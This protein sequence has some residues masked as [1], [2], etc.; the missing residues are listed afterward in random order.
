MIEAIVTLCLAASPEICRDHLLPD[1][2]GDR[3][4][5]AQYQPEDPAYLPAMIRCEG[6]PP[7]AS[8]SEVAPGVFVH[9]GQ[10][11]EGTSETGGDLSNAGFI[12]GQQSVAV[13]DSGGSRATG[14]ALFRALRRITDKPVSHLILTHMH[15]D[16]VLGATVFAEAGAEVV[17]HAGL[18]RALADRRRSYLD[19][20]E[21]LLGRAHLIG[22]ALPRID[23]PIYDTTRIDLGGRVLRV[24][25]WPR[26]H[27]GTD[28]T[29]N[30]PQSDTLFAGDLIFDLHTPAL[31]GSLRGWQKVLTDMAQL[32]PAHVVP[33]HGGPVM[34]WAEAVGPMQRYLDVLARDTQAALDQGLSLGQSIGRIATS[35]APH[36]QL[37]ETYNPRN[38]TVAYTE[39]E[40]E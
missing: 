22:T 12:I 8:V 29:V 31:D 26:S 36:W 32:A 16:H 1:R 14:E 15:P 5:A 40:W 24:D 9:R 21:R 37:F 7:A 23:R 6:A 2:S 35:Q 20:M 13:I 33:G 17:G 28:L 3:C 11:S 10:I 39:L 38:A 27:T 19:S 18:P 4:I 34:S 25:L 30:D